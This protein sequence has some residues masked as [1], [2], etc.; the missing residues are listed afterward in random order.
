M[1][2]GSTSA[3]YT[4]NP[5]GIRTSKTVNGTTT[6]FI[7]VNGQL[8]AAMQNDVIDPLRVNGY[9]MTQLRIESVND[10]LNTLNLSKGDIVTLRQNYCIMFSEDSCFFEFASQKTGKRFDSIESPYELE[11][12]TWKL[13]PIDDGTEYVMNIEED[14]VPMRENEH[15]TMLLYGFGHTLEYLGCD[16][17]TQKNLPFEKLENDFKFEVSGYYKSMAN[18]VQKFVS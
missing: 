11:S 16:Y 9:T 5:D 4:Y 17:I 13:I 2:N 18:D 6:E 1:T 10:E 12:S 7:L 14:I 8:V 3:S 15:C